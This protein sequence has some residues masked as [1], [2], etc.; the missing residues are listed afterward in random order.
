M[1]G[2][3]SLVPFSLYRGGYG[4][5]SGFSADTSLGFGLPVG[6]LVT[7]RIFDPL[8]SSLLLPLV[9]PPEVMGLEALAVERTLEEEP[10]PLGMAGVLAPLG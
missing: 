9:Q 7:E 5:V 2:A 4:N 6:F 10:L 8:P 3:G 1:L